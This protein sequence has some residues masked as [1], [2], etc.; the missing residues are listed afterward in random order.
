MFAAIHGAE[1]CASR[2]VVRQSRPRRRASRIEIKAV[3]DSRA[4][5]ISTDFPMV[6]NII[7]QRRVP[8]MMAYVASQGRVFSLKASEW[9]MLFVAVV[10]CGVLTLL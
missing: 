3:C 4:T 9:V 5:A 8:A 1:A 7:L 2:F 10:L 6:R